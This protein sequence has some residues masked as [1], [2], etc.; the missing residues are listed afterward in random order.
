MNN[1]DEQFSL[2][3]SELTQNY[4]VLIEQLSTIT[5]T[6]QRKLKVKQIETVLTEIG[7]L[8]NIYMISAK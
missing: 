6:E 4:R 2:K 1:V 8:R 5:D 7:N 3:L